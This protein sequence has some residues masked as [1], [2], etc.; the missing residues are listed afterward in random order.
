[1][2]RLEFIAGLGGALAWPCAVRAQQAALPVV[3]YINVAALE[4]SAHYVTAFSAGLAEIG[5]VERQVSHLKGT[6]AHLA[7]RPSRKIHRWQTTRVHCTPSRSI[8]QKKH[9][10]TL[11][12]RINAAKWPDGEQVVDASQGVQLATAQKLARYWVTV[13]D[14]RKAEAR[15]NALNQF[16]TENDG[17]NIHFIHVCQLSSSKDH[18]SVD[19]SHGLLD[20]RAA[21]PD[22]SAHRGRSH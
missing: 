15:L 18:R 6:L 13:H 4:S 11:R 7:N 5:Y 3:G 20:W 21:D 10:S 12:R 16:I 1:M 19:Q 2:R 9:L 17:L 14:W 8:F 22:I